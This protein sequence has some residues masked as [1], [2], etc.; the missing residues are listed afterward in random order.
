MTDSHLTVR[1]RALALALA[2]GVIIVSG[3]AVAQTAEQPASNSSVLGK[4]GRW[5]DRSITSIGD[6]FRNAGKNVDNFNREAGVAARATADVATGAA[7]VVA[8]IPKTRIVS[9]H[10]TCAIADNGAP[11]CRSA[12][13]HLCKAQGMASGKSLDITAAEEC[14]VRVMAG[15]RQAQPGECKN[16]TFVTRAV[17]Q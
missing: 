14:P 1:L 9:G 4:I 10:Q 3:S 7:D 2:F 5:F 8:K 11:D 12:A 6:Q 17:C 16:V 13:E 15:A